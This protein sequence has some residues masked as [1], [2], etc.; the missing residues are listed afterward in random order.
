V[1][2]HRSS[3]RGTHRTSRRQF[4]KYSSLG[5]AGLLSGRRV[6][7]NSTQPANEKLGIAVIGIGGQG[8]W[9][10][11]QLAQC[12]QA[13][14][15]LCDVDERRAGDVGSQ[16][17]QAKFYP[18]FRRMLDEQHKDIDAVLIATPDHT[19]AVATMA[20]M[21]AGKHVY[22]EKPLTHEVWETRQL[23]NQ[24]KAS[25]LV[26]QMGTQIHAGD[27]YRRTVELVQSGA[28]GA[29]REVHVWC[30]TVCSGGKRPEDT[31]AVPEG[32]HWDLWLGPAPERPYHPAY[33]PGNW[34]G[35][36][37][38]GGGG[39][40]DM[41]CHYMDL[42][43]W[44]LDL[45]HP[46]TVEAKGPPVEDECT[47]RQLTVHY[48][49][50]ARGERPPVKLTWCVGVNRPDNFEEGKIPGWDSGVLFVGEKGSL[51]ADYGQHKLLPEKDF[52]DFQRPAPFIPNSIGHHHE[53]IK[54]CKEGGTTTCNFEYSGALTETV[55]LGNV[56]YRSGRKLRWDPL[57]M[58]ISNA[59]EAERWLRRE[60]RKGWSL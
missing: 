10:L 60:Y 24:A 16:Y 50:P 13:I 7:G 22:C 36:W 17:P 46:L 15:A 44:A 12:N 32:L 57:R 45:R 9:N 11:G 5:A 51:I 42:A 40:G 30:P 3:Y 43:H 39:H 37:D 56:S 33:A 29:I 4:L 31:P 47:P 28:V 19:H 27:N 20:A 2:S 41:A 25:K 26:T 23:I 6:W 21:K 8:A 53:W 55:L 49:Y 52:A 59:P 34:R 58:R 1:S 54:A 48:E 38:F 35:W 14:V 18:D